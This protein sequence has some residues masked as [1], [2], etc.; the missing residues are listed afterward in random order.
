MCCCLLAC[1]LGLA[2]LGLAWL[3][4]AWLGLAWLGL[5]WL[6]FALL[7]FFFV[8]FL[9]GVPT[10]RPHSNRGRQKLSA[11][12]SPSLMVKLMVQAEPGASGRWALL[13]P[14]LH[15]DRL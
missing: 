8:S 14:E 15:I 10:K 13:E 12:A 5:A 7:C 6:C 1:L 3:G 11:T 9:A 4:L 2:W